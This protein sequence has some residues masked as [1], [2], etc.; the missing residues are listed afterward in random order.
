MV[1]YLQ[2]LLRIL[3]ASQLVLSDEVGNLRMEGANDFGW[4]MYVNNLM[5]TCIVESC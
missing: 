1:L 5:K 3:A 4:R 2:V